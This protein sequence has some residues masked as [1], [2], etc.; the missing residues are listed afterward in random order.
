MIAIKGLLGGYSPKNATVVVDGGE[1]MHFKKAWLAPTLNGRYI[2]GGLKIGPTQDRLNLDHT[3][4][5]VVMYNL[6]R[7]KCM[8]NFPRLIVGKYDG[9]EDIIKDF[10]GHK[11]SV[12]FDKPAAVQIDGETILDVLHYDV[13]TAGVNE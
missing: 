2:G 5:L 7:L 10:K 6:N 11:I 8:L 13:E 12:T 1:E 3:V 4:T 9:L